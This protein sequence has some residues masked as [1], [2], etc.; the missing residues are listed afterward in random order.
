M[1]GART[2]QPHPELITGATARRAHVR[3]RVVAVDAPRGEYPFGV[4]IL[5][6]TPDVIHDLVAPPLLNG[7]AYTRR[8]L[9]QGIIPGDAHPLALAAPSC[10]L[11]RIKD[12]VGVCDLVQ[13]RRPFGAV[14]PARA[15]MLRVALEL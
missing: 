13:G 10:T 4:S 11:D 2:I 9:I 6:R 7:L 14:A 12:A 8:D 3:M 5:A 15:R 1:I